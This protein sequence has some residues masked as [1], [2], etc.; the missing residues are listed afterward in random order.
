MK[1]CWMTKYRSLSCMDCKWKMER[2]SRSFG[3]QNYKWNMSCYSLSDKESNELHWPNWGLLYCRSN[4]ESLNVKINYS[5]QYLGDFSNSHINQNIN[6]YFSIKFR[7][8]TR[9]CVVD[10]RPTSC[11]V[12]VRFAFVERRCRKAWGHMAQ[13]AGK[14]R[15]VVNCEHRCWRWC[16]RERWSKRCLTVWR[17][18]C[19]A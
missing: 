8:H 17:N 16:V 9:T 3:S 2:S 19:N 10:C 11:C 12:I 6:G 13:K 18:F 15:N 5:V 7:Q 14:A 4:W 1:K